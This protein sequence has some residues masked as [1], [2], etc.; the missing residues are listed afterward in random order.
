MAAKI[1]AKLKGGEILALIGDLGAGKTTFTQGL[2][3]ALGVKGRVNSPTFTVMKLYKTKHQTIKNLVHIDAYRLSNS[4]DLEAIGWSD[5]H[6]PKSV[7]VIEWADKIIDILPKQT[8]WLKFA[9][10]GANGRSI[11]VKNFSPKPPAKTKHNQRVR[12]IK[13]R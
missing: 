10:K 6:D 13:N 9:V 7:V 2:A 12:Q 5:F 8:V 4:L 11:T 3:K 1:A